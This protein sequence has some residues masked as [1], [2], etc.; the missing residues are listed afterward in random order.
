MQKSP[1]FLLLAAGLAL[2]GA[3][4]AQTVI[5]R[6]PDNAAELRAAIDASVKAAAQGQRIGMI[7]GTVNPTAKRSASGAVTLELD[8]GTMVHSVARVHADG[9]I[10]RI[11]VTGL[12]DAEQAA[13]APVFAKR[14]T[15]STSAAKGKLDV[16]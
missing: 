10:E 2:A 9:S 7:T 6:V 15:P 12:Q 4:Q 8:A 16:K 3:T 11:C 5:V 14:M 13:L 1:S